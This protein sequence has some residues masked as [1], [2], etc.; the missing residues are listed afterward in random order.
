MF[1]LIFKSLKRWF[2]PREA[3]SASQ[4][5]PP[6]SITSSL[7]RPKEAKEAMAMLSTRGQP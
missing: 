1:M 3:S 4:V 5:P 2:Y 7:E 6:A